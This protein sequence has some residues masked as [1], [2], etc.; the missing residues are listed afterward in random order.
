MRPQSLLTLLSLSLLSLTT[1]VLASD[2]PAGLQIEKTHPVECERRT[3]AGDVIDVHY[4]GT[5]AS[6]GSEFDAS[7]NR[8]QPL[9]FTVG[10]GQVIK[11]WDQG[12]LDM[13]IGEKRKLTIAPELAYG[14][15][16]IGPIPG[17][18]TLIFETELVNIKGTKD[19]L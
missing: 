9:T 8:G 14:D 5:L 17:G 3:V 6:D 12:L 7:Y 13:C 16:G 18:S 1:S 15:R 10:K 19:E 11:G 4:R 2:P